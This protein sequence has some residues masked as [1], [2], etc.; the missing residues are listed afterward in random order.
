M[1]YTYID[2]SA[3]FTGALSLL[4]RVKSLHIEN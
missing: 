1:A 3:E 4:G 2:K